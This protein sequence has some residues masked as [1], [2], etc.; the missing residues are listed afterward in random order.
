VEPWILGV[1]ALAAWSVWS[2]WRK[3]EAEARDKLQFFED[4]DVGDVHIPSM[5]L[6]MPL[7]PVMDAYHQVFHLRRSAS[8]DWHKK[9]TEDTERC[10]LASHRAI[11]GW[12]AK[13]WGVAFVEL[14][15]EWR[16]RNRER[17][18]WRP[19]LWPE[20][21]VAYQ[22]FLHCQPPIKTN[23]RV[24]DLWHAE[25]EKDAARMWSELGAKGAV[26]DD[27]GEDVDG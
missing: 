11:Y 3:S 2:A 20:L 12:D 19:M 6:R 25:V 15:N 5:L 18:D 17:L 14:T 26:E 16:D 27:D 7:E 21:E 1:G 8:G 22:R 4:V 9:P 24:A 10:W 23:E 13:R